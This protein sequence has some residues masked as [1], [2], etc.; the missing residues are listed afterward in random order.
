MNLEGNKI[1]EWAG[2]GQWQVCH[3]STW[4][5]PIQQRPIEWTAWKMALEDLTP[6]RHIG[7]ALGDWRSHHH[8]IVEW[9]LD[10]HT[11]TL[12]HHVEGVWTHHDTTNIGR[13]RFQVDAH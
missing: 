2:H 8:H 13:L 11:C 9:Y 12:Y 6:D 4:E 10:A 5:W 1:E 7:E 3:Q